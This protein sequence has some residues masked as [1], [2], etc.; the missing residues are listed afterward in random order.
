MRGALSSLLVLCCF[1]GQI[2]VNSV[3]AIL[4][5][6]LNN[7]S[8][9]CQ[10]KSHQAPS[11]PSGRSKR[12]PQKKSKRICSIG[13]IGKGDSWIADV[14]A[15][16][17]KRRVG[18]CPVYVMPRPKKARVS[19]KVSWRFALPLP[20]DF[21]VIGVVDENLLP[22]IVVGR[23]MDSTTS[24]T[25]VDL[26]Y[27][28]RESHLERLPGRANPSLQPS[29][30][31]QGQSPPMAAKID[32]PENSP[33]IWRVDTPCDRDF[34]LVQEITSWQWVFSLTKIEIEN[35]TSTQTRTVFNQ[36]GNST[37]G[38]SLPFAYLLPLRRTLPHTKTKSRR[39]S[40]WVVTL[41]NTDLSKEIPNYDKRQ[42]GPEFSTPFCSRSPV[43][44]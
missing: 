22:K 31:R 18:S 25:S 6:S 14:N 9:R 33:R 13:Q 43:L 32:L 7:K 3:V 23:D 30:S 11:G 20:N 17:R 16:T 29:E 12:N 24:A 10:W 26:A 41:N 34:P 4:R 2:L 38:R 8:W 44:M 5:V 39:S 1:A 40:C 42:T 27:G 35:P 28:G 21:E 37:L 19:K 36:V 15:V